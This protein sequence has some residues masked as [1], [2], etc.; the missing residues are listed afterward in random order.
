L[1]P[2]GSDARQECSHLLARVAKRM[3]NA[4]G[5]KSREAWEEIFEGE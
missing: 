1:G 4:S 2:E 3:R 5:A